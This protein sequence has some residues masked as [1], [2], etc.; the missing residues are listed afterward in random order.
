MYTK[1]SDLYN[2][3]FFKNFICDLTSGQIFVWAP[4]NWF[5]WK[6]VKKRK[7]K[8]TGVGGDSWESLVLHGDQTSQS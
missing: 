1:E 2:D 4:K 5:F 7:E 3:Q 6:L 8:K